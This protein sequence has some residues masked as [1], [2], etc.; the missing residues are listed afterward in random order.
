[1]PIRT[2]TQ[3]TQYIKMLVDSD[4][5]LADVWV[6]GEVSNLRRAPSPLLLYPEG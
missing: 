3:V 1:M 4:L 2:V 6:E 5:S